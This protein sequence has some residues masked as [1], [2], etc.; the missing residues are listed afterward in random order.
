MQHYGPS[1]VNCSSSSLG[2]SHAQGHARISSHIISSYHVAALY[3]FFVYQR[4]TSVQLEFATGTSHIIGLTEVQWCFVH[5]H[6]PLPSPNVLRTDP[7]TP[8]LLPPSFYAL[9]ISFHLSGHTSLSVVRHTMVSLINVD[10][11]PNVVSAQKGQ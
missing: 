3:S 11:S 8:R 10:R 2:E 9:Y 5:C 6:N 1:R 4:S 7:L